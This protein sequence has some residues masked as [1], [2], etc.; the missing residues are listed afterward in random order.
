[1]KFLNRQTVTIGRHS[2][3][4][5]AAKAHAFSVTGKDS[6]EQPDN[7]K[8]A[9]NSIY[10]HGDKFRDLRKAV[11]EGDIGGVCESPK[12]RL[13]NIFRPIVMDAHGPVRYLEQ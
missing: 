3:M 4:T 8:N 9:P 13:E 12:Y 1:M 11:A 6:A 7:A 5:R 10:E 2:N